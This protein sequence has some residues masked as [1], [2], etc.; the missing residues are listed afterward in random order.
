MSWS[1]EGLSGVGDSAECAS[2]A[3]GYGLA[4]CVEGGIA[5]VVFD[6]LIF[7]IVAI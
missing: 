5:G 2:G 3:V 6:R 4:V 1:L 7:D